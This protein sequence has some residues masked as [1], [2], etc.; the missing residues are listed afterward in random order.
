MNNNLL[1]IVRCPR[2][3]HTHRTYDYSSMY[4]FLPQ[5]LKQWAETRCP[6][7][8]CLGYEIFIG[9]VP[10]AESEVQHDH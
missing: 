4:V 8:Q 9:L 6:E 1:V 7:C 5:T 10:P 2:C 3:N